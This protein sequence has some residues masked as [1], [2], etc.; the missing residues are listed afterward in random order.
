MRS[1][2]FRSRWPRPGRLPVTPWAMRSSARAARTPWSM[3]TWATRRSSSRSAS[4]SWRSS[5]AL[6]VTGRLHGRPAAWPFALVPPLAFGAQELI[7]RLV[8][9]LPAH[10]VFEPAV[11][12]GLA[13]QAPVA[14][15]AYLAARALLRVADE[16]AECSRC[17]R[18]SLAVPHVAL[19]FPA[20]LAAPRRRRARLRPARARASSLSCSS[21]VSALQF[22]GGSHAHRTRADTRRSGACRS[23]DAAESKSSTATTTTT[24][25]ATTPPRPRSPDRRSRAASPS[26]GSR[27]PTSRRA[28]TSCSSS[29]RTSPTRS[30]CTATTSTSTSTAGGT[31]RLPFVANIAGV[32]E[33][34]LESRKLQIL[35]LTVQ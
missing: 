27:A 31:A 24:T 10:A 19:P 29:T 2:L 9:G 26:A 16:A 17:S 21:A 1:S 5:L 18:I 6:R 13:A 25:T 11:Y 14:L 8:A 28:I 33:A 20:P 22:K 34:E 32:F 12:V 23:P 15:A 30:T 35:E 3:D 7:E 4:R